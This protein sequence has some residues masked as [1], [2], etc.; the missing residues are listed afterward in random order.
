MRS[1]LFKK[2]FLTNLTIFLA[3]IT[4]LSAILGFVVIN[5]IVNSTKND[6][7]ENCTTV[8]DAINRRDISDTAVLGMITA[9]SKISNSE[10]FV[11]DNKGTVIACGCEAWR[12]NGNC[13]LSRSKV[14]K[15]ALN[16]ALADDFF[17][18]GTLDG[19]YGKTPYFTVGKIIES[20]GG[21]TLGAVFSSSPTY[22]LRAFFGTLIRIYLLAA[23]IPIILMFVAEYTMSYRLLNPL[24][25]MS[26]AAKRMAK[27]DFSR[28]IPVVSDD[29]IGDLSISFNNMTNSLVKLESMRRSFVANVSHEL[30]TPMT[31]IGG[32]IDGILDGTID[33]DAQRHYLSVVSSEVKR[34]TRLVESMM[35]LAKLESG[36]QKINPQRFDITKA[37]RS[38]VASQS[39]RIEEKNV[40]II[41]LDCDNITVVAD[42]DLLYQVMYNLIDNAIK[43]VNNDGEIEFKISNADGNI[44]FS[45]KNT[46][47]FIESDS[48][49]LVFD[50]FFKADKSRSENKN[51]T[52]LGLYISKTIID[53]HGGTIYA[54]S[55][56]DK[57]TEFGFIVSNDGGNINGRKQ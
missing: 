11:C 33:G 4:F 16:S 28:R 10:I 34:L 9:L 48:I 21:Q 30:R 18:S 26:D 6:L 36:E 23:I 32:F 5:R 2:Y 31:T 37:A 49:K 24:R 43:F 3:G 54:N 19:F 52:G 15:D 29:E 35:C 25:Q 57:H 50:R 56:K 22:K 7:N 38:I 14:P 53:I 47:S 12:Q 45:I 27:G 42:Y 13:F 40:T 51:G 55:E 44:T 17:E 46:G 8:V 39:K 41:G 1:R 20:K